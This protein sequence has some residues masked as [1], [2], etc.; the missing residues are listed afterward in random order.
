MYITIARLSNRNARRAGII[1]V[2]LHGH[3]AA[4]RRVVYQIKI[5]PCHS[6]ARARA[7]KYARWYLWDTAGGGAVRAIATRSFQNPADIPPEETPRSR[8]TRAEM[9]ANPRSIGGVSGPDRR[10]EHNWY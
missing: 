6:R 7:N 9:A 10:V 1:Y 8:D 2:L 4:L 5:L 3:E